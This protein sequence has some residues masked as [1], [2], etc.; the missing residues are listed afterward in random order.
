MKAMPTLIQLRK[1]RK[2]PE[3]MFQLIGYQP[4]ESL[5]Q[6][7]E[8][9]SERLG[10]SVKICVSPHARLGMDVDKPSDLEV[11]ERLLN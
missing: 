11:A 3:K 8:R 9:L 7:A 1:H 10:I 6:I 2:D 5:D 4:G